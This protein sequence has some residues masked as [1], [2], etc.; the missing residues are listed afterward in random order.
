MTWYFWTLIV[1]HV[2]GILVWD[3]AATVVLIRDNKTTRIRTIII[4]YLLTLI[5]ELTFTYIEV[6]EHIKKRKKK[7]YWRDDNR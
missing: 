6:K 2:L 4:V 7:I 3:F 1:I 5:W